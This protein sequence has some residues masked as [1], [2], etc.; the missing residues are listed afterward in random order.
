MRALE[1]RSQP[2]MPKSRWLVLVPLLLGVLGGGLATS[3]INTALPRI[4][5]GLSV[6]AGSQAW[7]VDVYPLTLAVSLVPAVRLGNQYGRRRML[8]SGLIVVALLNI[9]AGL[10]PDGIALIACRAVL[11]VAGATVLASVVS[12]VGQTFRGHDLAVANGA[13]VTVVG[14]GGAVGPAAGGVLTQAEGWR[15]VFLS[16]SLL[17]A[18]AAMSAWWLMPES[19]ARRLRARWDGAGVALSVMTV[20]GMVYGIQHI[21]PDPFAGGLSL[22]AGAAA[23]AWF[24]HRQ[25]RAADPL[26]DISLFGR[27]GFAKSTTQILVSA[28]TAAACVYLVNLHLQHTLGRTPLEAGVALAPQAAATAFGGILAPVSL[29]WVATAAAIRTALVIQAAG[30]LVLSWSSTAVF[31]PIALVGLGYGA[32]ATLAT[33]ALFEA[34]APPHS[35]QAGAIQEIAFAF[36]SGTGIAFFSALAGIGSHH[37]FPLAVAT[38]AL[39]TVTSAGIP[40]RRRTAKS[41]LADPSPPANCLD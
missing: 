16:L 4:A 14:A 32:V 2:E 29:R 38:A 41:T 35:A 30:L 28:A 37:G 39:L 10:C 6:S 17:A 34:A 33:T 40:T 15:W 26:I 22:A 18:M 11:G 19:P 20:G 25:R 8:L 12:T 3:M 9:L 27:A 36:G 7:I 5:A 31:A 23:A 24:V 1:R 21:A 13:W